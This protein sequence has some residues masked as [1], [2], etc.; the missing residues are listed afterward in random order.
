MLANVEPYMKCPKCFSDKITY[1]GPE[2][3]MGGP[4]WETYRCEECGEKLDD[5]Q[6]KRVVSWFSAGVSSAVATKLANPDE[7]IYIHIDDQHPDTLRFV[8]DCE[9]WFGKKITR[10]H[11]ELK[12]VEMACRTMGVISL[13]HMAPCTKLLKKQIRA[14][15][16]WENPGR[17]T[18]VWGFDKDEVGRMTRLEL[19]MPNYDHEFPL[20]DMS[21]EEAHGVLDRAGIKRPAMYDL[22]YPNN[23][24]VGCLKGSMGYWNRIRRD[25]PDVFEKRAKME[26]EFGHSIIKGVY[27]DE[28]QEERGRC[29]PIVAE[30]GI[31]CE[32]AVHNFK[33]TETTEAK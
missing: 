20:K 23:N 18:Y 16:E 25:F 31:N 28:L 2:G 10:L 17:H 27:L 13:F 26:R 19:A 9:K 22:G 11:S 24:C 21:K 7:I 30:C 33:H 4:V 15:W 14:R 32:I 8:D 5:T 1:L 6:L 29:N 12:N 3:D